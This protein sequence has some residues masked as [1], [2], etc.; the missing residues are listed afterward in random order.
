MEI[1]LNVVCREQTGLLSE[2]A[3]RGRTLSAAG[4]I[5][6]DGCEA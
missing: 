5:G 6:I 4:A 3:S 1:Q 2:H